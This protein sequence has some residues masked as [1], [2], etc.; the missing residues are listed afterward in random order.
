[1]SDT[2]R[3]IPLGGVGE[4]GKNITV[5]EVAGEILVID[6]GLAFPDPEMLGLLSA[7]SKIAEHVP[8]RPLQLHVTFHSAASVSAPADRSSASAREPSRA[9]GSYEFASRRSATRRHLR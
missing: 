9:W 4:V 6:C 3:I 1:M 5:L 7:E 8:A 2:L